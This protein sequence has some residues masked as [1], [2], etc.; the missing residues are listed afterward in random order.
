M[1]PKVQLILI[2]ND[3]SVQ[4]T[5]LPLETITKHRGVAL[6]Q[7]KREMEIGHY[8]VAVML[9]NNLVHEHCEEE[10]ARK[11]NWLGNVI[12]SFGKNANFKTGQEVH[13]HVLTSLETLINVAGAPA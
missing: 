10:R 12:F 6:F 5:Y 3:F 4:H 7:P 2:R 9:L 1:I 8:D 11:A 13:I